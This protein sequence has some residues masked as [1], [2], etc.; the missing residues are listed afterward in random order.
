MLS[1]LEVSTI[2]V[3]RPVGLGHDNVW[4]ALGAEDE[5]AGMGMRFRA[6]QGNSCLLT[7]AVRLTF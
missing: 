4:E 6:A 1:V 7:D 5:A 2:L 3:D